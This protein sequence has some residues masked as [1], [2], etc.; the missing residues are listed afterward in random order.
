MSR[1]PLPRPASL[2]IRNRHGRDYVVPG[3]AYLGLGLAQPHDLEG[4]EAIP[5]HQSQAYPRWSVWHLASVLHIGYIRGRIRAAWAEFCRLAESLDWTR[6][7]AE[8]KADPACVRASWA[9]RRRE[10]EVLR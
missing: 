3:R 10:E 7:G 4:Q 6:P 9:M 1:V 2:T 8:V 5:V